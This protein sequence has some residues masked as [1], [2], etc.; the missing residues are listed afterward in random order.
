M[1]RIVSVIV[2]VVTLGF[3]AGLNAQIPEGAQ[4]QP[5]SYMI[6]YRSVQ[7]PQT[8]NFSVVNPSHSMEEAIDALEND[9]EEE[10]DDSTTEWEKKFSPQTILPPPLPPQLQPQPY[11]VPHLTFV[12]SHWTG[13]F[14]VAPYE[15]GYA[16]NPA[17]F[18]K[19]TSPLHIW[20]S[21]KSSASQL[22]PQVPYMSYY[23]PDPIILPAEI[24][25]YGSRLA[26]HL[27]H[28]PQIQPIPL[29]VPRPATAQPVTAPARTRIGE[30]MRQVGT[31]YI[32]KPR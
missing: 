14:H 25:L 4:F 15:P 16:A 29:P 31:F 24:Q 17:A 26:A 22:S 28:Q 19:Q 10:S 2:C 12:Y 20:T 6:P 9:D 18:P 30:R 3:Y 27:A 11:E 32:P 1:C 23:D 21:S 8:E 7:R 5:G 13:R